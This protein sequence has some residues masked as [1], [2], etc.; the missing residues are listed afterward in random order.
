MLHTGDFVEVAEVED[1]W[2]DIME[3]SRESFLQVALT[4]AP[5]NHDEY[6]LFYGDSQLETKFKE[7]INVP[8]EKDMTMLSQQ[9]T[10]YYLFYLMKTS[11][12]V[13]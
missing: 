3:Q 8:A 6:A 13:Y 2:V 1:E 9:H 11:Q 7:H 5:G 4:V 10:H 12:M